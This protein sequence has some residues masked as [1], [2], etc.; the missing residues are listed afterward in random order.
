[1]GGVKAMVTCAPNANA[2]QAL[3]L[4]D[5]VQYN[6]KVSKDLINAAASWSSSMG[7]MDISLSAEFNN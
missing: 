3:S 5:A 4:K 2:S 7:G 6:E 1:M